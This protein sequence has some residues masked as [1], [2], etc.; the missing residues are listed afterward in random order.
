MNRNVFRLIYGITTLQTVIPWNYIIGSLKVSG[1]FRKKHLLWTL[2]FLRHY[3]TKRCLACNLRYAPGI[4]MKWVWY[5]IHC[6]AKLKIVSS[7]TLHLHT[8]SF[9]IL[10]TNFNTFKVNFTNRFLHII[11]HQVAFLTI[12]RAHF[13]IFEPT[14]FD[15]RWFLISSSGRD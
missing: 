4:L 7:I 6:L 11:P 13:K 3:Q 2:R 8:L 10:L 1:S 9:L 5:T 15:S 12:D 14:P